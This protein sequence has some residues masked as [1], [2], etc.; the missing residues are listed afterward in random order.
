MADRVLPRRLLFGGVVV[1]ALAFGWGAGAA[2]AAEHAA[3]K[4]LSVTAS[5]KRLG[6]AGGT[7]VIRAQVRGGRTCVFLGQRAAFA[8]VVQ[9]ATRPCASGSA[10]STVRVPRNARATVITLHYYVRVTDVRGRRDEAQGSVTEAAAVIVPPAPAPAPAPA[11]PSLLITTTALPNATEGVSY[12]ATVAASGGTSPYLWS[13]ASGA[14]PSGLSLSPAG[15]VSGTPTSAGVGAFTLEA[16]DAGTPTQTATAALSITVIAPAAPPTP[17]DIASSNWSGYVDF[18][19]PYTAVAGTFNVPNLYSASTTQM[20]AEW[21]GIGGTSVVSDPNLIQAGVAETLNPVTNQVEIH[22]WW[23]VLPAPE[24]RV[25]L[26]VQS[27]DSVT[28]TIAEASPGLW[29]ISIVDNTTAGQFVTSQA[30]NGLAQSVEWIVEAPTDLTSM[31]TLTL[32]DYTPD[33]TFTSLRLTGSQVSLTR[34]TMIQ[35]GAPVSTAS[36]L[37]S[38][39]FTVGYGSV[40]PSAP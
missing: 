32:G 12:A 30:F 1:F 17:S 18:G 40:E 39:G 8:S 20:T 27:G 25:F 31:A 35:N 13:V 4:V 10:S 16:T 29:N 9:F 3:P 21:V 37:T 34:W 2:H 5:P 11:V 38:N 15:V 14:L 23:E 19:G 22:A 24:T 33:V 28:V 36:T 26:P 6:A 7:V